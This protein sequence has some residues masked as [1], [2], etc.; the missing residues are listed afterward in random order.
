MSS[1]SPVYSDDLSG[2]SPVYEDRGV[3][4]VA[5]L[6]MGETGRSARP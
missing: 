3:R 1:M 4:H 2:M 6:T 5:G